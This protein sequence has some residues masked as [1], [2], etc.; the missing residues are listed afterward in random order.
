MSFKLV[1]KI[2]SKS[3]FGPNDGFQAQKETEIE[4]EQEQEQSLNV[5]CEDRI[6]EL[7]YFKWLANTGGEPVSRSEAD[8]FWLQAEE[9]LNCKFAD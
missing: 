8:S 5:N 4:K 3:I 6:R 2:M 7:A 9:E 1:G